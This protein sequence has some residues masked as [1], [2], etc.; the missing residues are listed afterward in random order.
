MVHN[1]PSY[2]ASVRCYKA[3]TGGNGEN[4]KGTLLSAGSFSVR[5][6]G[7]EYFNIFP[8]WDWARVPGVTSLYRVP[9]YTKE[10]GK[11]GKTT[12][13]GGVS[14]GK[15]GTFAM[16]YAEYGVKARKGY[17][18]FKDEI[19][20][21][22]AGIEGNG[23][24]VEIIT[25]INQCLHRGDMIQGIGS[26]C[27]DHI[28]YYSIDSPEMIV[29]TD[30]YQGSWRDINLT[31]SRDLVQQKIF[32]LYIDH[33]KGIKNGKYS[34]VIV[35]GLTQDEFKSHSIHHME[36]L[37]NDIF[38]QAV[39]NTETHTLQVV[40][41]EAGEFDCKGLKL[42][43]DSPCAILMP[44]YKRLDKLYISDPSQKKEQITLNLNEKEYTIRLPKGNL[45]G[46]SI[47]IHI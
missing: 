31:Q 20:C 45:D 37:Q 7:D 4:L 1:N 41:Y 9:S 29:E 27:H 42:L 33:G 34:C 2:Q 40:F 47:S 38:V 44:D 15:T 21:L 22:G 19:I 5:V 36:V 12:F 17:F 35:P 10:W 46:S 30:V 8:C 14:D 16:D 6:S 39:A 13:V 24:N 18:F 28:G 43:V 26:V 11:S 32:S 3:E 25:S 23:P